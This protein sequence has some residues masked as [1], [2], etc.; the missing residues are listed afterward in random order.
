MRLVQG[1][2][3]AAREAVAVFVT[4]SD[5]DMRE[6]SVD[7]NLEDRYLFPNSLCLLQ[8]TLL[9]ALDDNAFGKMFCM[10]SLKLNFSISIHDDLL[11]QCHMISVSLTMCLTYS[12]DPVLGVSLLGSHQ[13][14]FCRLTSL[15]VAVSAV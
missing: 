13:T 12:H 2:T 10:F 5:P 4:T 8:R 1:E 6:R 9:P 3:Q 7:D 15:E 14:Q 11:S